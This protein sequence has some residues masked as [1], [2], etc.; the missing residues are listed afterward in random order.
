MLPFENIGSDP[1]WERYA[2]GITEDIVTDLS[3]SK[4]LF[5]VARNSTEV[6]RGKPAD[7]RT[8]GRDLGVRYVLEGSIQPSGDQIRVTAQ[9]IDARTGGHVWSNRYDRPATHLFK[10]QSD[11]TEKI[12]ATLTGYQGA[13][14]EAERSLVR[15][16]PPSDLTAY[17]FY[18]LG[19][20]AKHGGAGGGVTKEG[21]AEAERLFRRALEIDP[22][23]ARA[24]VGLAYVYEYR[25]EFGLDT[26]AS[27]QATQMEAARNAV[28]LDPN[29]R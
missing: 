6:Y 5:V 2:D 13:V 1:K 26:P 4:D 25:L 23:L 8:I 24:Y 22:Q 18:L 20:E 12:A 14:A 28:R 9:F 21:L 7:V 10:V 19:M 29:R 27:N 16:K 11:V 15:R 17:E 3:H